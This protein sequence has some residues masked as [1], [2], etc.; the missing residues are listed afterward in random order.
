MEPSQRIPAAISSNSSGNRD[1]SPSILQIESETNQEEAFDEQAEDRGQQLVAV[2]FLGP[3]G[4]GNN[5]RYYLRSLDQVK[6]D[7]I[8]ANDWVRLPEA[9][10]RKVDSKKIIVSSSNISPDN[11]YEVDVDNLLLSLCNRD[12]L[13]R[14][15]FAQ[16]P[17][18]MQIEIWKRLTEMGEKEVEKELL[19]IML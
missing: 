12:P 3:D 7:D 19:N 11:V 15:F 17:G 16:L 10:F 6:K 18:T 14:K 4:E 9:W 13:A 2:L 5:V 8:N 1:S